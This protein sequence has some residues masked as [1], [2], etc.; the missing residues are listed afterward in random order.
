MKSRAV[1]IPDLRWE[2]L[3]SWLLAW[4]PLLDRR[5]LKDWAIGLGRAAAEVDTLVLLDP[6]LNTVVA[7]ATRTDNELA[8]CLRRAVRRFDGIAD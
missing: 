2:A 1:E 8:P 7:P 6:V 4:D 3:S 5:V